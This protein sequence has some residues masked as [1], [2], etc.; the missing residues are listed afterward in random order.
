M[1]DM[2][3]RVRARIL[4]SADS[5]LENVVKV[6]EESNRRRKSKLAAKARRRH[7]RRTPEE[8]KA[9]SQHKMDRAK[10]LHGEDHFVNVGKSYRQTLA[11][12]RSVKRNNSSEKHRESCRRCL[13][14]KKEQDPEGFAQRN[15][16]R[17]K[18]YWWKKKRD[19]LLT[20]LLY[21][22]EIRVP[23]DQTQNQ[24]EQNHDNKLPPT[25]SSRQSCPRL[26]TPPSLP[27]RPSPRRSSATP[28]ASL[29]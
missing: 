19:A 2:M 1:S 25:K 5:Y 15:R 7:A 22:P 26:A 8:K 24:K 18:F 29:T 13:Q 17:R 28:P 12:I 27:R 9:M 21:I 23:E 10:E 6:A 14:R 20:L 3:S 16:E 11:G 4:E